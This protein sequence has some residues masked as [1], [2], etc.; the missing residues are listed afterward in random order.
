[1]G[2]G[3]A[4]YVIVDGKELGV[5]WRRRG[6]HTLFHDVMWGPDRTIDFIRSQSGGTSASWMNSVWWEGVALL[7]LRR[8]R[9]LV[10]SGQDVAGP[11]RDTSVLEIRAWLRVAHALWPRWTVTWAARE[12]FEVMDYLGLPYDTVLYLDEPPRPQRVQWAL[13]PAEDDD[14]SCVALTLVAVR[15]ASGRLSFSGLWCDGME[16]PLL[17]GPEIMLVPQEESVPFAALES[18]PRNGVYIDATTRRL[19][20]WSL[21]APHDPRTA[22]RTWTGWTL[23]DHG[24]AFEEVIDLIGPEILLQPPSGERRIARWFD[25]DTRDPADRRAL[26]KALITP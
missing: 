13:P 12:L 24:D 22:A 8:R 23:I 3:H 26:R 14:L 17:A 15:D 9:M 7:D 2:G 19:D 5:W 16:G 10:H 25:E 6:A 4:H 11:Q 18:V 21:D 20:W 1:M